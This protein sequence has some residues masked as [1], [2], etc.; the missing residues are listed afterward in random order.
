MAAVSVKRSIMGGKQGHYVYV[1]MVDNR[2]LR[3]QRHNPYP[4]KIDPSTPWVCY[5]L[6][7]SN[8]LI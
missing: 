2:V 4:A 6:I 1:K 5:D 7:L 8:V 3:G